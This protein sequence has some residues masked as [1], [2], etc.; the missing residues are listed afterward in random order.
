MDLGWLVLNEGGFWI[1]EDEAGCV[2]AVARWR[3]AA[4][5]LVILRKMRRRRR[6]GQTS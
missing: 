4:G 1:R 5:S 3:A 2:W 6:E